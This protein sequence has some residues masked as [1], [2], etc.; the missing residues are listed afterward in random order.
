MKMIIIIITT[1]LHESKTLRQTISSYKKPEIMHSIGAM[2]HRSLVTRLCL[3]QNQFIPRLDRPLT[4]SF[5]F[6][7]HT[8][9]LMFFKLLIP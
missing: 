3:S 7:R 6:S 2:I 1:L 5:E 8:P 4:C 9:L